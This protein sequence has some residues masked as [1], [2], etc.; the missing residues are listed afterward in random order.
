MSGPQPVASPTK[1]G[2][3]AK[4]SLPAPGKAPRKLSQAVVIVHGMGEQRP[5]GR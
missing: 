1:S 5:M 3:P 2:S 4:A